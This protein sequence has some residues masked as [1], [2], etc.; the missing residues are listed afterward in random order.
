[1]LI[2]SIGRDVSVTS[3]K[4]VRKQSVLRGTKG[5]E[6][7]LYN[8]E[9]GAIHVL[10][11]TALLIW[12]LCDGEHSLEDIEKAIRAEF[13]VGAEHPV[14]ED[15]QEVLENFSKEGLLESTT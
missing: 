3:G 5:D 8:E 10:N 2:I 9:S 12:N 6:T 15:I 11:P 14:S 4:P 13:S 1:V 7:V